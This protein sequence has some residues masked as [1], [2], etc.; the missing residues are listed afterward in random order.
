MQVG[1]AIRAIAPPIHGL[2]LYLKNY[3]FEMGPSM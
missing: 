1:Y 3:N 2:T